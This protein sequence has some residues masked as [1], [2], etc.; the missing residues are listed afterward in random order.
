MNY[1][2]TKVC[3]NI[4]VIVL[5]GISFKLF[6]IKPIYNG[7]S[8]YADDQFFADNIKSLNGSKVGFCFPVNILE[9]YEEKDFIVARTYEKSF[10]KCP[11]KVKLLKYSNYGMNGCWFKISN[12][13]VYML[14]FEI[15][16]IDGH[17][18]LDCGD[19][20]GS[21]SGNKL[22]LK[23]YNKDRKVALSTIRKLLNV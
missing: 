15:V 11:V 17:S 4:L 18:V 19:I 23:V 16:N 1:V 14:G 9:L 22:Y 21:L 12:F 8:T 6:E 7:S 13:S 3:V 10:V 20:I 5:M 2:Y